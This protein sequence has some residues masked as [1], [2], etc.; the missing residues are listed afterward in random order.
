VCDVTEEGGI[1]K[2]LHDHL[3]APDIV[4]QALSA[5][6]HARQSHVER[7]ITYA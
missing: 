3:G 4:A 5:C 7:A 2:E 6:E 1:V